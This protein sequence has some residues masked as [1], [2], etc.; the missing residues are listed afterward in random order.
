MSGLRADLAAIAELVPAGA[1][2]L[3]VGCGDGRLL[4]HLERVRGVEG[5]GLELSI[6]GVNACVARG[7]PVVQGDADRDLAF[8]PDDAFDL[9]ILSD[10]IQATQNPRAVLTHL[11]RIAPRAA[12]S[13]PNFGHW[14]VRWSLVARGRMPV[15]DALPASWWETR[16]IHLCTSNDFL[17][18]AEACGGRIGTALVVAGGKVRGP[19]DPA[20]P[21]ARG[22][23]NLTGEHA[24]FLV[25][26]RAR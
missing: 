23:A 16:N 9:A 3:D 1:R 21:L 7:L 11:L 25:E 12:V 15:S 17:D 14:R 8:Y 19:F 4:E 22:L 5:R 10:T 13:F 2:V 24:V 6:A 18:L 26:R 20:N